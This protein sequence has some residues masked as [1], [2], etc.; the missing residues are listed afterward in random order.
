MNT[1]KNTEYT[2]TTSLSEQTASIYIKIANNI[3]YATYEGTFERTAF[4][5]SFNIG[6]IYRII[7][8]CFAQFSGNTVDTK[9]S[10]ATELE[11]SAIRLAFH[12][13]IGEC[14]DVD[15]EI[16][17]REKAVSSDTKMSVE[18]E[19]QTQLVESLQLQ[20]EKQQVEL[21]ELKTQNQKSYSQF[22][23]M[24]EKQQ[25]EFV[26]L[27]KKNAELETQMQKSYSQFTQLFATQNTKLSNDLTKITDN[28]KTL[29]TSGN[30]MQNEITAQQQLIDTIQ[31]NMVTKTPK[32]GESSPF[33]NY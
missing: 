32:R 6:G 31:T 23:Q 25:S 33:G 30:K 8:K 16:R 14:L 9:C 20:V 12:C 11:P 22:T 1:F 19:K 28:V 10:I 24:L 4:R 27:K 17:V 3:S 21:E 5:L 15:F 2:I 29:E 13:E 18:W 26:E 7:N